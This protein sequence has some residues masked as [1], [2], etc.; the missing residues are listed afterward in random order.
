MTQRRVSGQFY[1]K[2][3]IMADESGSSFLGV[4]VGALLVA[5]IGAAVLF[6]TGALGQKSSGPSFTIKMPAA[7]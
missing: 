7:K 3:F 1:G 6:G 2:D 4:I 5:F